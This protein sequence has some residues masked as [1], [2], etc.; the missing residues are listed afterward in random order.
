VR[1]AE[2]GHLG[3]SNSV[4]D[5][6]FELRLDAGPGYRIYYAR[7]GEVAYLL[8]LGGDKSSQA[9]DIQTAIALSKTIKEQ[10]P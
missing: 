10:N 8:L 1:K 5:G 9:H 4:G 2:S 6:V 7:R 3:D